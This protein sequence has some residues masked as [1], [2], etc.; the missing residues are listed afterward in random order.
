MKPL[1]LLGRLIFG[2]FFLYNGIN[3]FKNRGMLAQYA[4]AKN[5]PAP[6][7]A[8]TGSGAL[9]VIGG[10]SI[11]LGVKPKI[12]A[13][14]ILAFLAGVSP[15][16]HDFW[17]A[18]DPQQRQ[19]DMIHFMKNMALLGAAL[20]LMSIREP[21]PVSVPVSGA[22]IAVGPSRLNTRGFRD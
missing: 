17:N 10:L 22:E 21:W 19:A 20:A 3:H 12:G 15:A 14:A 2:A 6:E 9:L 4:G 16:I 13:A 1:F 18:A 11:I 5:V 8:V 7:A